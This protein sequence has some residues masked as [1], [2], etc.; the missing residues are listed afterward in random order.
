MTP[1]VGRDH[2]QVFLRRKAYSGSNRYRK[3]YVLECDG[4]TKV[5]HFFFSSTNN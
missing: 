4:K 2:S 1:N 3:G 5:W